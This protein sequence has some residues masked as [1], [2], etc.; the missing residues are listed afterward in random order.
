M[1]LKPETIVSNI[2]SDIAEV[3]DWASIAAATGANDINASYATP[4]EVFTIL[5]AVKNSP[6]LALGT[7][8]NEF[9]DFP[10]SWSPRDITDQIFASPDPIFSMMD[11][12]MRPTKE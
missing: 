4:N 2:L 12:F 3:N 8:T 5:T 10:D 9:K 7:V 1:D 11:I 6:D